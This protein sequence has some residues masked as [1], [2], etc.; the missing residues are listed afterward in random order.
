MMQAWQ[1]LGHGEAERVL[2]LRDVP[3]PVV[4]PGNVLVQS[5]GFGLNYADVMAVRG[6]YRDAPPPPC[7]LGYEA[8]GRVTELGDGVPAGLL[9][10]RVVAMTRFGGYAERV[11]TDHRAVAVIP[12]DMPLG[13]ATALA[14][15]GCTAWYMAT[16]AA[17]LRSGQ[18]VLVHSAAGG[19]GQLL[20]QLALRRGCTVFA[21]A[22]GE[23]K[24]AYLRTLGV[25]HAIDRALGDP[26]GQVRRLL[27]PARID[28]GFNA[29]GGRSF[30]QDLAL[31]GSGGVLV[32]FGG[33]E[34]G[35][36]GAF[37]TLRF[38]WSMG[39]VVP[40]LLM[41]RS[42]GLIGVN[43]LRISEHRPELIAECLH[44]VVA[45][46]SDG[47]LVPAV[48]RVFHRDGLPEAVRALQGG[49]TIG[50]VAVRW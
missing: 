19:V 27:G 2:A 34:R 49:A 33:A 3:D 42:K 45:A 16:L 43:M 37:G 40:I 23:R 8:V 26:A 1:L 35:R 41:M 4:G 9:G 28:V 6:L 29:V 13:T 50:K 44:G 5:E 18:R 22:S 30:K 48:H 21:V 12:E 7:V 15:Q 25:H 32:L 46:A 10:K 39:V 11:A 31:L 14:T 24:M 47:R 38:V 36:M 17:P 20:V